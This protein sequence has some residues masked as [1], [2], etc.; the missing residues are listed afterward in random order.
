MSDP[1]KS[2]RQGGKGL[3]NAIKDPT[4]GAGDLLE[5]DI[6]G[7]AKGQAEKAQRKQQQMIARQT[8]QEQLR[9]AEAESEIGRKKLLR[10]AGGRRSLIASR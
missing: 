3:I 7:G 4:A 1:L 6:T 10:R 9:L 5:F 2:V 8:Q